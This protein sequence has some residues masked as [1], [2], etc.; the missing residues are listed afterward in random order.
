MTNSG[1]VQGWLFP[2]RAFGVAV[3]DRLGGLS[4]KGSP[5]LRLPRRAQV[6]AKHAKL[7]VHLTLVVPWLACV[8]RS[9][10][11]SAHVLGN[12]CSWLLSFRIYRCARAADGDIQRRGVRQLY[13]S[14]FRGI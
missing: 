11:A 10:T 14:F 5:V 2:P 9:R 3:R 7:W 8:G 4:S 1:V 13:R 12:G 6:T